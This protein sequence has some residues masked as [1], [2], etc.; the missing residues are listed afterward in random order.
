MFQFYRYWLEI[1]CLKVNKD[2]GDDIDFP[3]GR[4]H[5]ILTSRQMD[6]LAMMMKNR[7]ELSVT[8]NLK[9]DDILD[10]LSTN[11]SGRYKIRIALGITSQRMYE[12][13]RDMEENPEHVLKR[14]NFDNGKLDFYSINPKFRP[15]IAPKNP[16]NVIS[17]MAVQFLCG[18][19][20]K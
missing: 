19:E 13:L 9:D 15:M 18:T 5:H 14:N 16:R 20:E 7:H 6:V 12:L 11:E 8:K 17:E 4:Q 1:I 10:Q 3:S 2:K